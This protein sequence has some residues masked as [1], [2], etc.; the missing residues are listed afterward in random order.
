MT[1]ATS[2]RP[3]LK[4][5][6]GKRQLLPHLRHYY[7]TAITG[8]HEPFLGSGAVFFDLWNTGRLAGVPIRLTDENADLVGCYLRLADAT[9]EVVAA[10]QRLET[11]HRRLGT[12]H[13]YRV[14]DE[15]FNPERIAW[16]K[17]GR[18]AAAYSPSLAAMFIY[19]NRTGYNGLFRQ[20]A[21]GGFNVPAG[22]YERPRIL[23][24]AR[25]RAAAAVLSHPSVTVA[26]AP[27]DDVAL[28]AAPGHFVYF[29]PPYAPLSATAT[30]RSYTARGFGDADQRRLQELA[31][32]LAARGVHVLLSNSTAPLITGLF[33]DDRRARAAGLVARRIPARRAINSRGD[34]R[35]VIEEL[36][37]AT[38]TAGISGASSRTA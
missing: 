20:N 24:E 21:R 27:F 8:Y 16:R 13:Y 6:G 18:G 7:P 12:A 23:D 11:A 38:G 1:A 31:I 14:R 34:R 32:A 3:F 37:V 33:E 36:L 26:E 19:L 22:R 30:F 25:L 35:G 4:W 29:D 17:G 15:R 9:D 10:L 2:P 5:A 28:A